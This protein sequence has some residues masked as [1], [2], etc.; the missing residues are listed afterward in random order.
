MR[1]LSGTNRDDKIDVEWVKGSLVI[2][3]FFA[4]VDI[5]ARVQWILSAT[6]APLGHRIKDRTFFNL[7][8]DNLRDALGSHLYALVTLV[9]I[10]GCLALLVVVGGGIYLMMAHA[11]G[12]I[13]A[14]ARKKNAKRRSMKAKRKCLAAK[15]KK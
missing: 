2:L 10:F 14:F 15:L 1:R 13:V 5:V 6:S 4:L 11:I 9:I 12:S 8:F 3:G 7:P